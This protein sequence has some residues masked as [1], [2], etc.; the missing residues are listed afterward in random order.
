MGRSSEAEAYR[1]WYSLALWRGDR[2]LRDQQLNR[3]PLCERCKAQGIITAA[4]VVNHRRPHR[5]DWALFV[6]PANHESVCKDHH[7]TLVQREEARGHAIGT[8]LDGRPVDP[9]HP[10]NRK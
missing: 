10:W 4:T 1:R 2:G 9:E 8:G 3:E 6:D 5:G 7:D